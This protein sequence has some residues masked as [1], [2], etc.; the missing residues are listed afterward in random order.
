M[1]CYLNGEREQ[2][3]RLL[4]VPPVRAVKSSSAADEGFHFSSCFKVIG[5][6]KAAGGAA[7]PRPAQLVERRGTRHRRPAVSLQPSSAADVGSGLLPRGTGLK[8]GGTFPGCWRSFLT[9]GRR[10][11]TRSIQGEGIARLIAPR[12]ILSHI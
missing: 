3:R 12:A 1:W 4:E 6:L 2:G 10:V 9:G 5:V 8:P 11:V 7:G